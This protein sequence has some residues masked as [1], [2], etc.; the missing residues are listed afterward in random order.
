M[1]AS[2][3]HE[4]VISSNGSKRNNRRKARGD[5]RDENIGGVAAAKASA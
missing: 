2:A 5:K 3:W 1:A 4:S